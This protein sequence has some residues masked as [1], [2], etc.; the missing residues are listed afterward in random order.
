MA[1]VGHPVSAIVF[2]GH[3]GNVSGAERVLLDLVNEARRQGH[4][5]AVACPAGPLADAL[6][7]GVEHV[8]L[9]P[10]GLG[11][12]TGLARAVGAVRLLL[13][14]LRAGAILR[15]RMRSPG[16]RTIVNS[17][18]ALP[19]ARLGGGAASVSWLVHDTI[20]SGKQRAVTALGRPA[21][22][23][24]VAV[25]EATAQPLRELGLP[26]V[27]AHNG[28][29]WPVPALGTTVHTPAVVGM[30]AL[31]TPWKG[32]LVLLDA[33][34]SLPGVELQL[35]GGNFP[36]DAA[37][38]ERLHARARRAD[39]DGRVRFL[40]HVD[41]AAAMADWDVVVSA[42]VLPEAGP[43]N[44]LEAMSYGMPVV[45]SDHGGTSEFLAGGAGLLYP[46]GDATALAAAIRRVLDDGD[47]RAA[48]G[49]R[50]RAYVAAHHDATVT[51][52]AMLRALAS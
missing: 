25:S 23:R 16:T 52:P 38:V 2:V 5:V 33:I 31:L 41:P 17:M 21:V 28:V 39:L 12:E 27:V 29:R 3:T 49:A 4:S 46:P 10:L 18:Y 13:R 34:A 35:A 51:I 6:P 19:A 8:A 37:Y 43:L 40:G 1:E 22:R 30:L 7:T 9:P 50:A 36:S 47:L 48:L 20:A 45:G 15:R 42:S 24:A 11:G 14:W 44:V 32:H 26:V